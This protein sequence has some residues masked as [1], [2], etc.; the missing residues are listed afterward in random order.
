MADPTG[1]AAR[2]DHTGLTVADLQAAASWFCDVFGLVHELTARV[3]PLDLSIEMLIH[4]EFGYRL[5]LLHRTGTGT[6]G[7]PATPGEAA[8][9]EGYGHIAF[10]VTDL[11]AAYARA[12]ARGARPVMPP[13]PSPERGVLMA[14]IADPEGNLVELLQRPPMAGEAPKR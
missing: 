10:D 13:G 3:E 12:V 11:D 14:F 5:E 1:I 4:P 6:D 7:K 9:R 2:L 8:L